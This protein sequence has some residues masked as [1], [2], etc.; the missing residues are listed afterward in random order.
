MPC[1][2]TYLKDGKKTCSGCHQEQTADCFPKNKGT[3]DGL[4]HECRDCYWDDYLRRR[5][6][7]TANDYFE[8]LEKQSGLCGICRKTRVKC[9]LK[10]DKKWL[11]KLNTE[12]GN[13]HLV[14]RSCIRNTGN[15]ARKGT[16]ANNGIKK[17]S[18]C[19]KHKSTNEFYKRKPGRT[20]DGY[21]EE[22]KECVRRRRLKYLYG[23]TA[24]EYWEMVEKQDDRCGCC[25][26][27]KEE[28]KHPN[29]RYW[30]VDHCHKTGVVRELVC[31]N[32]NT[33]IGWAEALQDKSAVFHYLN[34]YTNQSGVLQNKSLPA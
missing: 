16:L 8:L 15:Y 25:G 2:G 9:K 20:R 18:G 21:C 4:A 28:S 24:S 22:C 19:L 5:Y 10:S 32:C 29:D 27:T 6:G 7:I 30:Y 33:L 17:C 1:K 34:R 12:S 3:Q 26:L 11:V 13:L 31:H 23:I 14:C